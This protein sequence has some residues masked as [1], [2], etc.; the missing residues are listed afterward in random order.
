V[1]GR[2]IRTLTG[3]SGSVLSVAFS[4]NAKL[5]ASGSDHKLVKIWDTETG[6]QVSSFVGV[7]GKWR[8]GEAIVR[9]FPTGFGLR[10]GL[11]NK[12]RGVMSRLS[13]QEGLKNYI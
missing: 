11:P 2:Q 1:G 4:P 3:H 9:T 10:K 5:T 12:W 13:Y 6:A 8:G 7:R